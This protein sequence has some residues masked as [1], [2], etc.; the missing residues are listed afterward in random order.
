[1]KEKQNAIFLI[2]YDHPKFCLP[3]S[4]ATKCIREPGSHFQANIFIFG[5]SI[6][7]DVTLKRAKKGIILVNN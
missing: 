1:L 6:L 4:D 3:N 2:N 5:V 7:T